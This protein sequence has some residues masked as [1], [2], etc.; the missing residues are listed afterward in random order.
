MPSGRVELTLLED[1]LRVVLGD[2]LLDPAA[3]ITLAASELA[4]VVSEHLK[5]GLTVGQRHARATARATSRKRTYIERDHDGRIVSLVEELPPTDEEARRLPVKQVPVK[6][7][8][9]VKRTP[10]MQR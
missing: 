10:E 3:R 8:G 5:A 6:Q 9:F 1:K 7:I 4:D 2:E